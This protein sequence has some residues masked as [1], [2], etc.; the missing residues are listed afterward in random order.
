MRLCPSRR[1][2]NRSPTCRLAWN[3]KTV[4][5]IYV[6]GQLPALT[7]WPVSK[8]YTLFIIWMPT[9]TKL[10]KNIR[11]LYRFRIVFINLG[12]LK[13]LKYSATFYTEYRTVILNW[14]EKIEGMRTY[15]K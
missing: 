5:V 7:S 10:F 4:I 3:K 6:T 2:S 15:K 1:S 12:L 13:F 9:D 14:R 11:R 8:C